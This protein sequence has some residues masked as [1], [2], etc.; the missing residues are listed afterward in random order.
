[1]DGPRPLPARAESAI[2]AQVEHY[3][4][5]GLGAFEWKLYAHDGPA[6]L[7]GLLAAAGFEAEPA[8]TLLVAPVAGRSTSVELPDD[9]RLRN[10]TDAAG[11]ELMVRAHELAFG[12]D[13]TGCATGPWPVSPTPRTPSSRWSPWPATNR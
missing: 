6:G 7:G 5:R 10:V 4:A 13:G 1:M 11:V 9:V 2:A 8:E 12:T 3:T